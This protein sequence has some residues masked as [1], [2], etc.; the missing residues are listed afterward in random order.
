VDLSWGK[1]EGKAIALQ[2]LHELRTWDWNRLD[3]LTEEPL[4][5]VVHGGSGTQYRLHAYTFWDMEEW[6]SD[7]YIKVRVYPPTGWRRFRGYRLT[8]IKPGEELP[9]KRPEDP[10]P[11]V[12][13][14]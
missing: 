3:R 12:H 11:A 2:S 13:H 14:P 4:N 8:T 5:Q 9:R 1:S 10:P 6:G 7:L